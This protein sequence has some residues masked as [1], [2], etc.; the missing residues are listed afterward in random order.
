MMKNSTLKLMVVSKKDGASFNFDP[1]SN[2]NVNV[3]LRKWGY[4][5][6]IAIR[7]RK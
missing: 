4:F 3:V 6:G 2:L 7:R 1:Y 5:L